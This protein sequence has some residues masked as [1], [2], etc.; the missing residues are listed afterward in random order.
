MADL[1]ALW[2]LA[3]LRV[4]CGDL[5]LRFLDDARLA[6]LAT[7][8]TD[9]IHAPDAPL[10]FNTRWTAG[11]PTEVVRRVLTYHW[12]VRTKVAPE[13]WTIELGL[14]RDGEILGVQGASAHDFVVNRSAE[15]GSWLGRR[16]QGQGLGTRMR[17]MMLH[18]LFEGFDATQALTAAYA[19]NPR[20]QGVT[21]RIG[22]VPNGVDRVAREGESVESRRF[23]L[24]RAAWDERPDEHRLDVTLTGVAGARELL[25]MP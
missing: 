18:L 2:P 13:S 15:T 21:R 10:P 4:T 20:S 22:Y 12:G 19:D 7:L 8:A 23:V 6:A 24:T 11:T 25:G 17:L 9:G 14:L 16:Y 1:D 5:E 3:A